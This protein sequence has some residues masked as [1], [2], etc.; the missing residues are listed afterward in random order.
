M[1]SVRPENAAQDVVTQQ[2]ANESSDG[3]GRYFLR[4]KLYRPRLTDDHI[5]RDSLISR[6]NQL[7]SKTLALVSAPAGYGKTTLL[8]DWVNKSSLPCA[9]VSLD[10]ADNELPVFIGYM[11][12]AIRSIFPSFGEEFLPYGRSV[13][14]PA[15]PVIAE[16]LVNQID[17]LDEDFVLVLDDFHVISDP[18]VYSLLDLILQHPPRCLHLALLTRHDPPL[19][20]GKIRASN[21]ILE[22]RAIDLRFSVEESASLLSALGMGENWSSTVRVLIEKTKG[23]AVG[24]RLATSAFQQ[25]LAS[26]IQPAMLEVDNHFVVEYLINEVLA[27]QPPAIREFLLYSSIFERFTRPLCQAVM[28]DLYS[29]EAYAH[30]VMANGLFIEP[31]DNS[32]SWFHYHDFFRQFLQEQFVTRIGASFLPELHLKAAEWFAE[33][34][35]PEQAIVY[36][37]R[38]GDIEKAVAIFGRFSHSL[39]NE[40]NWILV[41]S[42]LAKFPASTLTTEP[43][44]IAIE[45]W[46]NLARFRHD[47]VRLALEQLVAILPSASLTEE[48]ERF[49]RSTIAGHTAIMMHWLHD[50]DATIIAAREALDTAPFDWIYER[51][52]SWLHLVLATYHRDGFDPAYAILLEKRSTNLRF[53]ELSKVLTHTVSCFLYLD[54]A[55]MLNLLQTATQAIQTIGPKQLENNPAWFI[56]FVGIAQYQLNHLEGAKKSFSSNWS[57][58]HLVNPH[59]A[60]QCAIGLAKVYAAEGNFTDAWATLESAVEFFRDASLYRSLQTV[61]AFQAELAWQMGD[62]MY[63]NHWIAQGG[64][65]AVVNVMP[66]LY[67]TRIALPRLLIARN[68]PASKQRAATLLDELQ[69]TL[70]RIHSEIFLIE[71]LAL[72]AIVFELEGDTE[73]AEETLTQSLQRAL[74]GGLI[75]IYVDLGDALRNPLKRLA[76]KGVLPVY[77]REI[78]RAYTLSDSASAIT[79]NDR[80][81]EPLTDREMEVIGLLEQRLSNKE[82]AEVLVISPTTAKRHTINI[83]QKLGVNSR[84]EAVVKAATLGLL[85]A[86]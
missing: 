30:V 37:L 16:A 13:S 77:V 6:L 9:W 28:G 73:M 52:F 59:C 44:L 40:E 74:P 53:D 54:S 42:L 68:T 58:R 61:N 19:Y 31:L 85:S 70:L 17:E 47:K 11:I 29:E 32:G 60:L 35:Q 76:D 8:S 33:N 26:G 64:A 79:A 43:I 7:Q 38:G 48:G 27:Q 50:F 24:L 20:L 12:Q 83:Y 75:R 14:L 22:L 49:V 1:K 67:E 10:T 2:T 66:S 34:G 71:V 72:R 81:V 78:L 69:A 65:P 39:M 5:S 55:D 63:A 46:L 51:T 57:H 36:L 86:S 21:E 80:L 41:E 82:I 15:L 25:R 45:A 56:A 23:W 18:S 62:Q 84:R 3:V 4:T